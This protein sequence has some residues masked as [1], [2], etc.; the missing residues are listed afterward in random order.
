MFQDVGD[1]IRKWMLYPP[2]KSKSRRGAFITGLMITLC[3]LIAF[4]ALHADNLVV[5]LVFLGLTAWIC[6]TRRR[7]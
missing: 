7:F 2:I 3:L 6:L 5:M 1:L 4:L